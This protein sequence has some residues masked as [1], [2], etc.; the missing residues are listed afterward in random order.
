MIC[1]IVLGAGQSRRMGTQKL[2]L[3][4]GE[5][6]VIGH[7]INQLVNS[8]VDNI[9]TVVGHDRKLLEKELSTHPVS[10]VV[11]PAYA[12]G[13]LS[14]LRCGIGALPQNCDAILATLGDQPAIAS[15]LIDEMTQ[16]FSKTNKTIL[17]PSYRG[18]RG[19]P[20]LISKCHFNEIM[21]QHDDIGL[22]GLLR[23]HPEEIF[24]L[25]V[26]AATVL[27]DMDR[28]ADYLREVEIVKN[29]YRSKGRH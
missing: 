25:E 5:T 14:S 1:A 12:D 13:M 22:R 17:A 29:H 27:S 3:P 6:T 20:T 7:I 4:F 2:L 16:A 15:Q 10:I 21:Q 8:N 11:N 18:K 28:P 24:E 26:A 19:H 23:A 9:F